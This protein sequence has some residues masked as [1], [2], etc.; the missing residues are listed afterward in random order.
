MNLSLHGVTRV[1]VYRSNSGTGLE[2]IIVTA[3]GEQFQIDLYPEN[4]DKLEIENT[5]DRFGG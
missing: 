5:N 4:D 3:K 1:Q 2:R